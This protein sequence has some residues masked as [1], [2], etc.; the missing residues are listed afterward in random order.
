MDTSPARR[1]SSVVAGSSS[2]WRLSERS[3]KTGSGNIFSNVNLWQLQRLFKAAGDHDA[4]QRAQLIWGHSDEAELAQALIGRRTQSQRRGLR[5][6]SKD[7]L[8][9]HWLQ[10]FNH[11]RIDESLPSSQGKD[12]VNASDSEAGAHSDP[13]PHHQSSSA[14][15]P[16]RATGATEVLAE[17]RGLAGTSERRV[18]ASSG[19][20]R[21]EKNKPERYLHR[22]LH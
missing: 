10:A 12:C 6:N 16:R 15:T 13:E 5:T 1:S 20:R 18:R 7:V 8:G 2:L 21:G 14:G 11:L 22:I 19:A 4:E 17:S 3:R 9:S